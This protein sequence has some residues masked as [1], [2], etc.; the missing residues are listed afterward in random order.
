MTINIT[1]GAEYTGQNAEA[2]GD[3]E[4][5]CTFKQGIK[6]F[7][8]SG[9]QVAGLKAVARLVRYRTVEDEETGDTKKVPVYFSVFN[10]EDFAARAKVAKRKEVA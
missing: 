10:A 3:I 4:A 2:C 9:K 8:I 1:T 7:G 6:H 5:V